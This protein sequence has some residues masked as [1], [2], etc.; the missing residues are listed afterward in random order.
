MNP[1][2]LRQRPLEGSTLQFSL[3][4]PSI[5]LF[6][7][8]LVA[9][10]SPPHRYRPATLPHASTVALREAP[11]KS[12]WLYVTTDGT[13]YLD[14]TP[15]SGT[16]FARTMAALG[17]RY[18]KPTFVLYADRALPFSVIRAAL[19]GVQLT[20]TQRVFLMTFE[21]RPIELLTAGAT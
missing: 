15:L 16:P 5:L 17:Q 10:P 12:I 9:T 14:G 3:L 20:G 8:L 2:F 13:L 1:S 18:P 7:V 19:R 21:G 4:V 11:E 6:L